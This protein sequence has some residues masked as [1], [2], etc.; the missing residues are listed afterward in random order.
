MFPQN[1]THGNHTRIYYKVKEKQKYL[2]A[3]A[4]LKKH[5]QG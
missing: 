5:K 2:R 1:L 3:I 4:E